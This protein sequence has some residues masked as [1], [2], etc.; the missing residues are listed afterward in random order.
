MDDQGAAFERRAVLAPGRGRRTRLAVALPIVALVGIAFVGLAGHRSDGPTAVD[1]PAASQ[2]ATPELA[3][4]GTPLPQ[5]DDAYPAKVLGL[6]VRNLADVQL[7]ALGRDDVVAIAGWYV[8]LAVTDCPPLARTFHQP[9]AGV[10]PGFDPS[11]YCERSGVL[12]AT[13][14]FPGTLSQPAELAGV[15]PQ[16]V[17]ASV[18]RGVVMPPELQLVSP[19]PTPV[20]VLGRFV[21]TSS[22]CMLVG[23]CPS[24]LIVDYLGWSG[25]AT[26]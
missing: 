21:P 11:A 14:T 17:D 19:E 4:A 12:Y 8:T 16:S 10:P 15:G 18:V 25:S 22:A 23:A 6:P 3:A 1:V 5:P 13:P 26:D 20:V 7:A 2:P 9:G 24:R